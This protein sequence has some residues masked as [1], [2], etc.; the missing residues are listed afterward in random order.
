MSLTILLLAVLAVVAGV[1]FTRSDG[2]DSGCDGVR[3]AFERVSFV[4]QA[5]DVPTATVYREAG[6]AVRNASIDAAPAVAQDL[7]AIADAYLRLSGL[8]QG[9]R[10]D[11]ASTYDV[12]EGNVGAIE[13]QQVAVD[14]RLPKVRAWLDHRCS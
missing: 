14:G 7:S 10:A 2:P 12:Y 3:K 4:E 9:F 13:V 8:L 11:D 1:Q 6:L 5:N